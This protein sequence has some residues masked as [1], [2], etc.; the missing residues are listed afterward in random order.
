MDVLYRIGGM[1]GREIGNLMGIGYT[2]VSQERKQTHIDTDFA[3]IVK[4][5]KRFALKMSKGVN[6]GN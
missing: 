4:Q 2:A 5:K 3:P 1:R 6:G